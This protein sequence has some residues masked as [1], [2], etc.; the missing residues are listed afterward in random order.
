MS[1]QDIV[2]AGAGASTPKSVSAVTGSASATKDQFLK[3]L[4]AQMKNQ[5]PLSPPDADKF[6]EQMTQFGQLEQLFNLNDSMSS[7]AQHQSSMDRSQAVSLIGR[8][9]E[10]Q[11]DQIELV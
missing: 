6:S 10:A 11:G 4:I 5:D 2:S 9:V 8:E 3:L 1:I 7:I